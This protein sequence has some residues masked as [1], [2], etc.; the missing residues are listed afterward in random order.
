MEILDEKS[1]KKE[2]VRAYPTSQGLTFQ[3]ITKTAFAMD[4]D[5]QRDENVSTLTYEKHEIQFIIK[6]ASCRIL[7]RL[8]LQVFTT[9]V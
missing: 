1:N 5:C 9:P 8:S 2:T 4:V 3:V 7:C 6:N